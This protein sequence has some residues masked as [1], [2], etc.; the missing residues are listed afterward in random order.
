MDNRRGKKV[1][2]DGM[3]LVDSR[4]FTDTEE[5]FILAS[6]AKQIFY[7]KDNIDPQWS[8]V[9][10]GKRCIVG[11]EDVVD[12]ED[13]DQFDDT[14]PLSIGFQTIHDANNVVEDVVYDREE[15]EVVICSE[16]NIVFYGSLISFNIDYF[17][18]Q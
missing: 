5:P 16:G 14:P 7:V 9:V 3:T 1:S 12:E 6:Q 13:F 11:V 2:D 18:L 17:L 10:Q 15:G 8:V 4:R